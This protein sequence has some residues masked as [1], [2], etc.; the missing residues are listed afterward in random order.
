MWALT[1]EGGERQMNFYKYLL[2]SLALCVRTKRR[3]H[4]DSNRD[5]KKE[6]AGKAQH[7]TL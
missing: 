6:L 1:N 5:K 7:V 3:S 4:K 2:G